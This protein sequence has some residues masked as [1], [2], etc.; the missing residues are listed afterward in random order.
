MARKSPVRVQLPSGVVVAL[1]RLTL[2]V[3]EAAELAGIGRDEF[4]RL[5]RA[6]EIGTV[7][8][9]R[10]RLVPVSTLVEFLDRTAKEAP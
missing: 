7:A 4:R 2:S 6:G 5:V 10:R 3:N 8:S 9:G 1:P